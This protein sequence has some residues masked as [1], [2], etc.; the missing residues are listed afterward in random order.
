MDMRLTG[1]MWLMLVGAD[2]VWSA[3]PGRYLPDLPP[4]SVMV[5]PEL[6]GDEAEGAWADESVLVDAL[7]GVVLLGSEV[8]VD[9]GGLRGVAGLAVGGGL[10]LP[11][12]GALAV[13]LEGYF[14]EALS[15]ASLGRLTREVVGHYR[16]EGRPVVDVVV[17]P[18]D[19]T[20]G[21]VQ[22]VVVEGRRGEVV[23]RGNEH[24]SREMLL[25]QVRT[26][27]GEVLAQEPL[28]ED[29]EWLNSNP[30]R[31]V[32]LVYTPGE[33]FGVTDIVLDVR[34]ARPWRL[35]AGLEDT[36]TEATGEE[37]FVSGVSLGNVWGIDHVAGYQYTASADFERLGGHSLVYR[38][39]LPWR[40]R[41]TFYGLY[42]TTETSDSL[43]GV[44]LS[45]GGKSFQASLR[46]E[47][48]LP[49]VG[50]AEQ[51]LRAGLDFKRTDNDLE[52][53]GTSVFATT[54]DIFQVVLEH[55]VSLEDGSGETTLETRLVWSPGSVGGS[56]ND[57]AFQAMRAGADA[58]YLYGW[59]GLEREQALPWGAELVARAGGQ[60]SSSNLLATEQLYGGGYESVRG[61]DNYAL[62]GDEGVLAGLELRAPGFSPLGLIGAEDADDEL[63]LLGFW[64]IGVMGSKQPLP[65]ESSNVTLQGAGVGLRYRIGDRV[66]A[67]LDYGWAV[68]DPGL[69]GASGRGYFGVS[70]SF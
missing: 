10:E 13:R 60:L 36:G 11:G 53:G 40:H 61:F 3:D 38:L 35:Y 43:V 54:T 68:D 57:A 46:Y 22:L 44:P 23:V 42:V 27:E 19:V 41:L 12:K 34:E 65:G 25:R 64:D 62:R 39:P 63:V 48:P 33:E 5:A 56:N 67:R 37:L 17:V 24:F 52:F 69:G 32:N 15:L 20:S 2:T 58:S 70:V 50:E 6:T 29:L 14:G 9:V 31:H 51:V 21:V 7:R 59:M 30:F 8:G 55:E 47:V 16:D 49:N 18:Q 45:T 1:L 4:V 26:G 66:S 28:L